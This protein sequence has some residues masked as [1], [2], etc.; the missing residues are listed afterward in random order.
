MKSKLLLALA[1]VSSVAHS[2]EYGSP[3]IRLNLNEYTKTYDCKE[4][5]TAVDS[6]GQQVGLTKPVGTVQILDYGDS[7]FVV[8]TKVNSALYSDSLSADKDGT[9]FRM[10]RPAAGLAMGKGYGKSAG[11]YIYIGTSNMISWDC[12]L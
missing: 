5:L 6:Q 11:T 1:L 3:A 12:R 10:S 7:F 4:L 9:E 2:G 8:N